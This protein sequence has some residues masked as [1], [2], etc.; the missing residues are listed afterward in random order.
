[1][2][3]GP[4]R[5]VKTTSTRRRCPGLQRLRLGARSRGKCH[6]CRGRDV[7]ELQLAEI[8]KDNVGLRYGGVQ[9]AFSIHH[10]AASGEQVLAAV[11]IEVVNPVTPPRLR[12][13]SVSNAASECDLLEAHLTQVA[14]QRHGL[15]EQCRL[16]D[17]RT[18]VIVDVA[19]IYAIPEM[20]APFS[21]KA[22]PF[23]L[24]SL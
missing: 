23:R 3:K 15:V 6:T 21:V 19:S 22:T 18:A 16:E 11:V 10:V 1:M 5:S 20:A 9:T 2:R 14:K 8:H 24:R 13:R 4:S 7:R 12:Q 17:I